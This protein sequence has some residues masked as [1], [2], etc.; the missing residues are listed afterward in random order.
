MS[1]KGPRAAGILPLN[2]GCMALLAETKDPRVA[3][4]FAHSRSGNVIY[5]TQH[6]IAG[7]ESGCVALIGVGTGTTGMCIWTHRNGSGNYP[8][9]S[10]QGREGKCSIKV[11]LLFKFYI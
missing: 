8:T 10:Q 11:A 2:D 6:E 1:S 5:S 4:L 3:C 7:R 9:R